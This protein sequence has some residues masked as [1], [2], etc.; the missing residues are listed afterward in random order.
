MSSKNIT[1]SDIANYT[2][3][4]KTTISRYFNNRDSLTLET[5]EL[6]R[7]ALI[8]LDYHENKLARALANGN[9]EFIGIIVP[10]LFLHYYSEILNQILMSYEKFG[11]KFLVF[12]GDK[13]EEV[14]KKYIDELLAFKI[15]GL[16]DL[17]HTISSKDLSRYNI[18]VITIEREDQYCNSVNADNYLGAMM[19]T[20][21]LIDNGCD[22]LIHL[23]TI[24][25]ENTP[26]SER[27]KGFEETCR[28][29]NVDYRTI[30]YDFGNTREETDE[31]IKR[32]FEECERKY[33][34]RNKGIFFANDTYANK[35]LNCVFKKYGK[36]PDEY[37]LVGYDDSSIAQEGILKL[38]TVA[39]QIPEMIAQ[40]MELL[41]G[42]MNERKKRKPTPQ[43]TL[44]HK[45]V[46]PKLIVRE[47][48][49]KVKKP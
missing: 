8:E 43:K 40:T 5:Q 13:D 34:G 32:F 10:N 24:I 22:L 1:F 42:L 14:E 33:K 27:I 20:Q 17:S 39:Q 47:T 3:F 29:N 6:I 25:P 23:N 4:S 44:V 26:S 11:Y 30:I 21:H 38:T 48:T 19:A 2:N 37:Q 35:F 28:D 7:N 46:E 45:R 16:I 9:S 49:K 15:E 31:T 41:V 36:L 12:I 18:P